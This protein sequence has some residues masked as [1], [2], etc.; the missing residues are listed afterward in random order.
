MIYDILYYSFL[1]LFII[2]TSPLWVSL[3]ALDLIGIGISKLAELRRG[4]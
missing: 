1:V 2:G 3:I 4:A